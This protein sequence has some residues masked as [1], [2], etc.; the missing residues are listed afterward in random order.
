MRLQ[1]PAK[2]NLHLRIGPPR[3]DGFHPLLS[4]MTTIGLFDTLTF[5]D[6][7]AGNI[8]MTCDEPRLPCDDRNLVVKAAKLLRGDPTQ[9]VRIHLQ[10]KIPHGGGLGGGSSD[11]AFTLLGLNRFWHLDKPVESLDELAAKL[12][13]DINFFLHG[14]SSI[15]RGRGELVRPVATPAVAKWALLMLPAMS[16]PTPAVYRQFDQMKLGRPEDVDIEPDWNRW[17]LLPS[18]DLLPLL[19]ND[20]E[21]PA[22]AIQPALGKLRETIEK[23]MVRPVRMSGSGSSLFTLYDDRSEAEAAAAKIANQNR[24]RTMA[25]E[26]ISSDSP[27]TQQT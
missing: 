16:M 21:A 1:A 18:Q 14:P 11:A 7:D 3:A 4:W 6:G 10:K 15:C 5:D 24:C 25:F 22:F 23:T 12:G 2:I 17:A 19:V 8:S 27:A 20:L 9:S 26:F 13:S